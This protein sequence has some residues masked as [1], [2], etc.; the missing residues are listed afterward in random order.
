[1]RPTTTGLV[2]LSGGEIVA[3]Q[4]TIAY[5]DGTQYQLLTAAPQALVPPCTSV[6]FMGVVVPSGYFL[7]DG[8]TASRTANSVLFNCLAYTAVAATTTASSGSVVVANSALYQIG[9]DVGGPNVTC[10]ST[11]TGIPDGT[12]ITISPTAGSSGATILTIGPYPQGDCSTTFN[13][14]SMKGVFTAGVDGA[15]TITSSFCTNPATLGSFCG[16][17][18]KTLVQGNMPI[19][20]MTTNISDPGHTHPVNF[21]SPDSLTSIGTG[22]GTAHLTYLGD[23]GVGLVAQLTA[24]NAFTGITASTPS[25]GSNTPFSSLPPVRLVYK[26][27]KF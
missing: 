15:G 26:I 2:V 13:L 9:W 6:D 5:Y 12:H 17:Q 3:T 22:G 23:S 11:I 25:G 27:I 10:N 21:P 7:E 8:S 18:S 16:T 1:M 14:P 20:T 4:T 19:Y 24:T